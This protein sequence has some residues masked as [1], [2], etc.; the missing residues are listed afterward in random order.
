VPQEIPSAGVVEGILPVKTDPQTY[1]WE[2]KTSLRDYWHITAERIGIHH[3]ANEE[4]FYETN[5]IV[6]V[7]TDGSA[8]YAAAFQV[9]TQYDTPIGIDDIAEEM[10][11]HIMGFYRAAMIEWGVNFGRRHCTPVGMD[12]ERKRLECEL[13][14]LEM[15]ND[16]AIMFSGLPDEYVGSERGCPVINEAGKARLLELREKLGK[17]DA[18]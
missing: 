13:F 14:L 8:K 9:N 6:T 5:W 17:N 16:N 11:A 4:G 7:S 1:T 3:A 15:F 18:C 2:I 12:D 10:H